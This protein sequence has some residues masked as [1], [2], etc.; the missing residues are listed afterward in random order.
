[1]RILCVEDNK[2]TCELLTALLGIADLEA[3]AVPDAASALELIAREQF[4]LYI[5]DGQMPNVGGFSFCEEIRRVDK[6]TPIVFFTG[7]GF[8]ADR[9]AGMLAGANAYIVKPDIQEIIPTVRRLLEE[10]S[11]VAS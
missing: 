10:A 1:M 4:S 11:A 3:V 2:D 9:E 7:K 6:I 5:I 8:E